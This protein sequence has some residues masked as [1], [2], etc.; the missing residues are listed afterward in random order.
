MLLTIGRLS[1]NQ[2]HCWSA[3]GWV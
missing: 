2:T 3:G 1:S